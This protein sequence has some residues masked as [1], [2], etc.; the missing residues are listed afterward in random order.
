MKPVHPFKGKSGA[1][2]SI[3]VAKPALPVHRRRVHYVPGAIQ[4]PHLD[5]PSNRRNA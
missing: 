1:A 3:P 4:P 2:G 5:T